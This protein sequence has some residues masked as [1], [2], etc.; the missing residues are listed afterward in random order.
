MKLVLASQEYP[1][2]TARGGIGSQT[3]QKAHTL[4]AL[5][6]SVIV[7]SASPDSQ[8]HDYADGAVR[9]IRIPCVEGFAVNTEPAR[10]LTYSTLVA[11]E[12]KTLQSHEAIDLIDFPEWGGEGFVYLLNRTQWDCVRVVVHLHGP[13]VMLAHTIGWPDP[14]SDMFR[15]GT[16]MEELSIRRADAVMSSSRCSA[17]WCAEHY[18]L[19]RNATPI[20]HAGIDCEL[21][22][23]RHIAKEAR[24]TVLC[25][26]RVTRNKGA[27]TLVEAACRVARRIPPLRLRFIGAVEPRFEF[28]L[29]GLAQESGCNDMLEF[30][31]H[32]DRRKLPDHFSRAH[33]F[34]AP[35]RYEGG[36][37]F[38]FLEAMACGLAAVGC[39]DSG[40]AETITHGETG[41]LVPPDDAEALAKV[42]QS[43]LADH[44]LRDALGRE[45]RRYAVAEADS[46]LCA[47]RIASFYEAIVGATGRQGSAWR[48]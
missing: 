39:T 38:V 30:L 45:A 36:P 20:L 24:P 26:G 44:C 15:I 18:Q 35:S 14:Q 16:L 5:G 37:G 13:V 7:V 3:F 9:V 28:E 21:F 32:T 23:P 43:L 1:P 46:R 19:D 4:A 33:I 6:H 17:R 8:R 12:L 41:M 34:V 10:W 40:I 31:T 2:E 11:A 48:D 42:M 47:H 22:S 27:H 29:R 25:V